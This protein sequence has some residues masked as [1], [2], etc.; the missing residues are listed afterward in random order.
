MIINT[1][2]A[3]LNTIRQLGVNE[4]AVQSSLAKLSSGFRI[5]S[6]ADDAAGLAISEKMR[7]QISGLK[8][9]SSNAQNSINL[10]STAEGALN[11]TTSILQ[12]M[13]ELAVQAANDTNTATDRA[14]L[15]TETSQLIAEI[16]RIAN[17]TQ[18]NTQNL[19]TGALGLSTTDGANIQRLSQTADTKSGT[20][21]FT[22]NG[23]MATAAKVTL[24]L[25]GGVT[26]VNSSDSL[27][28]VVNGKTYNI[29]T[30]AGQ[31]IDDLAKQTAAITG[32]DVTF[33][34]STG[35]LTFT[36]K[37]ANADQSISVKETTANALDGS[38]DFSSAV[39]NTGT[40]ASGLTAAG[41]TFSYYGNNVTVTSGNFKG[42][43]F[44]LQADTAG[45][46]TASVNGE[47]ITVG[48]GLTMQIGA[49]QGQTMT[50]NINAMDSANLGVSSVDVTTQAGAS[51]AITAIDNAIN[52]VSTERSKLGAYQ[53]RLEHTINNLGT[54]AQN[55]TAAEA[56]I[57]D[58]DMAA[59][60][61]NFQKNNILQQAAQA[62]LAQANQQPQ[63][64][65]Q[66]LR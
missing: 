4:K 53:N 42:L 32:L 15:Q 57:R 64:V 6:A 25:A 50:V 19:L 41:A 14:A 37:D 45:G 23:T 10:V 16:D 18:F 11:E 60:M 38:T 52:S 24:T 29:A 51:N 48:S 1:N 63:G 44:T 33:D 31:T 27:T 2:I 17:T 56:S 39:A 7:G 28:V 21:T 62:M 49:N 59:E 36:T 22:A 34:S 26:T 8:Q 35:D 46:A 66:L 47:S 3:S 43:S 65:L 20:L 30:S 9:A 58:V 61:T 54:S 13:R 40:N 5:N 12:R 55:I